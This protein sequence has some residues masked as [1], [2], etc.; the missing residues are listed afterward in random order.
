MKK[1]YLIL[2]VIAI[3][4]AV[5]IFWQ[6]GNIKAVFL[7]LV[8][9]SE[10]IETIVAEKEE[11]ANEVLK[12]TTSTEFRPLT[13][14]EAAKLQDGSLTKEE[15][16]DIIKGETDQKN[17]TSDNGEIDNIISEI[18]L[19][20]SSYVSELAFLENEAMRAAGAMPKK[21]RTA[22][23]KLSFVNYFVSKA[24]ALEDKCDSQM[25]N[26]LSRLKVVLKKQGKGTALISE[27]RESY[28]SQK[29][30]KKTQLLNKYSKYI[31]N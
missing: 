31:K 12:E 23:K 2:S 6:W 10:Q 29:M 17:D 7:S 22:S 14:E 26:I 21:D 8:Y 25:E 30:A 4:I 9:S 19:L 20:R 5:L 13:E 18:Y 15:A 3:L 1:F 16:L 28:A 11:K 24:V 27:I